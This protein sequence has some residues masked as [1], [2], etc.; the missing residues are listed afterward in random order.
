MATSAS[1]PSKQLL[2]FNMCHQLPAEALKAQV[3]HR[4]RCAAYAAHSAP[5]DLDLDELQSS[6]DQEMADP[7]EAQ[8]LQGLPAACQQAGPFSTGAAAAAAM[9]APPCSSSSSTRQLELLIPQGQ[10]TI[11]ERDLASTATTATTAAAAAAQAPTAAAAAALALATRG[12]PAG[13]HA[14]QG[15]LDAQALR[16][17]VNAVLQA[18]AALGALPG[19]CMAL[20]PCHPD[21]QCCPHVPASSLA[22]AGA[23]GPLSA[24]PC[25]GSAGNIQ[26]LSAAEQP[27]QAVVTGTA[28][29]A[30]QGL[31]TAAAAASDAATV[32]DAAQAALVGPRP[33]VKCIKQEGV[34]SG[35]RKGVAAKR[36]HSSIRR[37]Q[38]LKLLMG[39][40]EVS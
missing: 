4:K 14:L 7:Q 35:C 8:L 23:T 1:P 36:L 22:A 24:G 25:S 2:A 10:D 26:A 40:Y 28:H 33:A 12:S 6:S 9:G 5:Q 29:L 19:N 30:V 37:Q 13:V 11:W 16:T 32:A 17:A 34:K 31:S 27:A 15:S 18:K 38:Q 20:G 3:L 21:R 39:Q